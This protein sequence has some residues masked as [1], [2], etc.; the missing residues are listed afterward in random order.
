MLRERAAIQVDQA[1]ENLDKNLEK[2][3]ITLKNESL[4][5]NQNKESTAYEAYNIV[6]EMIKSW[7]YK[8][9]PMKI[10]Q[11]S[12]TIIN[13]LYKIGRKLVLEKN[14]EKAISVFFILILLKPDL[15]LLWLGLAI[16][17]Q[18]LGNIDKAIFAY[19]QLLF[20]N[21]QHELSKKTLKQISPKL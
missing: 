3:L 10:I 2:G 16:A 4:F 20:L 5:L 15:E 19:E 12:N 11:I 8:E 9:E 18:K 7:N 13:P 1:L 17:E 6:L 14:Y 21:P